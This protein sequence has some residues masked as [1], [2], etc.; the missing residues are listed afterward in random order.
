LKLARDPV[1]LL[2]TRMHDILTYG[3]LIKRVA[4]DKMYMLS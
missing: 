2:Q 3:I 1:R 4:Q